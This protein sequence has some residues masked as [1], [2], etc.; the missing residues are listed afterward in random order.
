MVND[1]NKFF[2]WNPPNSLNKTPVDAMNNMKRE[3][4]SQEVLDFRSAVASDLTEW[5]KDFDLKQVI[6]NPTKLYT[7][8]WLFY[9]MN[10]VQVVFFL[11]DIFSDIQ[12]T[13]GM[14]EK[15]HEIS[16][17]STSVIFKLEKCAPNTEMDEEKCFKA[18]FLIQTVVIVSAYLIY[19]LGCYY[20][21][22]VNKNK[23]FD[24]LREKVNENMMNKSVFYSS[25]ILGVGPMYF[26]YIELDCY[27]K[28]LPGD[29]ITK[30]M[31]QKEEGK[32]DVYLSTLQ[33]I[34]CIY[35]D[36]PFLFIY[37]FTIFK[38][39]NTGNSDSENS[40]KLTYFALFLTMTF[41]AVE[42]TGWIHNVT[43][44]K[45]K[46][47]MVILMCWNITFLFLYII[48]LPI[49]M[50]SLETVVGHYK[51][52]NKQ[53]QL[54]CMT[55]KNGIFKR[56]S[57]TD[58]DDQEIWSFENPIRFKIISPLKAPFVVIVTFFAGIIIRLFSII[59]AALWKSWKNWKEF[60]N[61]DIGNEVKFTDLIVMSL[62]HCLF[63]GFGGIVCTVMPFAGGRMRT[64]LNSFLFLIQ[65]LI[66]FTVF[67]IVGVVKINGGENL[68]EK[69][70]IDTFM[71]DEI[72]AFLSGENIQKSEL[73]AS[74]YTNAIYKWD[75]VFEKVD[76]KENTYICN[77][78]FYETEKDTCSMGIERRF[79]DG[80]KLARILLKNV[81]D[82]QNFMLNRSQCETVKN[83]AK[84]ECAFAGTYGKY[85]GKSTVHYVNENPCTDFHSQ[86]EKL[87]KQSGF[88][89]KTSTNCPL[90]SIVTQRR[91]N[92]YP[93]SCGCDILQ[94]LGRTK[95]LWMVVIGVVIL[96]MV[97][98]T[99]GLTCFVFLK[100]PQLMENA[101]DYLSREKRRKNGE[102]RKDKSK[103]KSRNT[104]KTAKFSMH[105]NECN[106]SCSSSNSSS[107]SS[108]SSSDS[109]SINSSV[110]PIWDPNADQHIKR[111]KMKRERLRQ[112]RNV[113]SDD[114]KFRQLIHDD[115]SIVCRS[116]SVR[117]LNRGRSAEI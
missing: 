24:Y 15:S 7:R 31:F 53:A 34:H 49:I 82:T 48:S 29:T 84:D 50:L 26:L 35:E 41:T 62:N 112:Q 100:Y 40:L 61:S 109:S 81:G 54:P 38:L 4:I 116:R 22:F 73:R 1:E 88:D 19:S 32:L 44:R 68:H 89:A 47:E 83:E 13:L 87:A 57:S 110:L 101:V 72:E 94:A 97:V 64:L 104:S 51:Y 78:V 102:F 9:A 74:F 86:V 75:G 58:W 63:Y 65:Y 70:K 25:L 17:N 45:K 117:A 56:W 46:K 23:N 114:Q 2:E 36:I 16:G 96:V 5:R 105:P 66:I 90:K 93:G 67:F 98:L 28:R 107:C 111:L 20:I 10:M 3:H 55:I 79:R 77:K 18:L 69:L 37:I 76:F 60:K 71:I 43:G 103:N 11:V 30:K 85:T 95:T 91:C 52:V 113:V 6:K 59:L 99:A 14:H 80:Q 12:E 115:S 39:E 106:Q 8:A 21:V 33:M 27:W 108:G 42:F 92:K